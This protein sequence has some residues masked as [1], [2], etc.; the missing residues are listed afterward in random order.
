MK[1]SIIITEK[2]E[3]EAI[4]QNCLRK[5]LSEQISVSTKIEDEIINIKQAA[6]FL[7]LATQTLYGFTSKNTIP[8]L[9]R[10]KKLY[11]RKS[12]LESWLAE[13]KQKSNSEISQELSAASKNG[14]VNTFLMKKTEVTAERLKS[15]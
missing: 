3:I 10:G 4:I 6:I 13:G 14:H 11:F 8:F 1:D 12:E 2:S 5:V 9:K 15:M 7:N